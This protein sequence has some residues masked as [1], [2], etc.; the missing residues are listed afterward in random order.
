M[1]DLANALFALRDT[2]AL[3]KLAVN[4]I[5]RLWEELPPAFQQ[6]RVLYPPRYKDDSAHTGR[7]MQK[8]P[9]TQTIT[10]GTVSLRR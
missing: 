1:Q 10:Q 4:E 3:T 7:F 9:H 2:A 8:K 5:I 6:S